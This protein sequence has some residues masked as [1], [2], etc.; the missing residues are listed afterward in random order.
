MGKS[1]NQIQIEAAQKEISD[2]RKIVV[3]GFIVLVFAVVSLIFNYFFASYTAFNSLDNQI[4]SQS[5]KIDTLLLQ[6]LK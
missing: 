5:T 6:C 4:I 1:R 2:L 3:A